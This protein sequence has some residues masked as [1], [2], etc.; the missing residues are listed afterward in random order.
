LDLLPLRQL[1]VFV[2]RAHQRPMAE[3]ADLLGLS[4]ETV[5]LDLKSAIRSAVR[6]GRARIRAARTRARPA[7]SLPRSCGRLSCPLQFLE[8]LARV[9][10]SRDAGDEVTA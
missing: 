5:H 2:V 6:A 4:R 1:V 3:L 8:K 9:V 7:V 10:R